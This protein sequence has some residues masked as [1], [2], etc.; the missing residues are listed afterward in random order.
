MNSSSPPLR[1]WPLLR[2]RDIEEVREAIG[3]AYVK[4]RLKS[5]HGV[6][7][8]DAT[9]NGCR[10]RHIQLFYVTYGADMTFEFD[11]NNLFTLVLPLRGVNEIV[12]SETAI[13][14]TPGGGAVI[15]PDR[16]HQTH[17]SADYQ[18][19][20]MNIGARPLTE[21]LAALTG[22]A[23]DP[24]LRIE[25]QPSSEHPAVR[26][27]Q[28][29]LPMLAGT[30]DEAVRPLPEWWT[31]HTEEFLMTLLLYG[32]RHNYSGLLE[33]EAPAA[34]PGEVRRAEEY[35]EANALRGVTLEE[36]AE[37]AG[38]SALSLFRS[39]KRYRGYSPFAFLSRVRARKPDS[40][41]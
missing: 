34:A 1:N 9:L 31:A 23:I 13:S 22:A 17:Y 25:T 2:S 24:P 39:F 26:A 41:Q 19:I 12:C 28:R 6:A 21:K 37:V 15:A 32:H 5:A 4:P 29:Y 3:R 18:A 10:L 38:V 7:G 33:G 20:I 8:L 36:L 27:L 11:A 35:I 30:L 40:R 16:A 14:L